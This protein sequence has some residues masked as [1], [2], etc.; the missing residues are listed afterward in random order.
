LRGDPGGLAVNRPSGSERIAPRKSACDVEPRHLTGQGAKRR[1]APYFRSWPQRLRIFR[2]PAS[3]S[4]GSVLRSLLSNRFRPR[5]LPA[6]RCLLCRFRRSLVRCSLGSGLL[7]FSFLG[8][9]WLRFRSFLRRLRE[10]A[11]SCF[12]EMTHAPNRRAWAVSAVSEQP[13]LRLRARLRCDPHR[14]RSSVGSARGSHPTRSF[15]RPCSR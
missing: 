5:D 9:A 7:C 12:P 8:A 3:V 10:M 15:P 2:I 6:G 11:H 13:G 4:S 1:L 14:R